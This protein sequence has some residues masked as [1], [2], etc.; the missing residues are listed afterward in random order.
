MSNDRLAFTELIPYFFHWIY[1]FERI[2]KILKRIIAWALIP[3]T[4]LA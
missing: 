2:D 1:L 3:P 4:I